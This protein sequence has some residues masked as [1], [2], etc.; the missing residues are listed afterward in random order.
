MSGEEL[1]YK[2]N[3]VGPIIRAG[4]LAN[5]AI[6]AAEIDNEGKELIVE[7]NMAYVRLQIEGEFIL[8]R[9]TLEEMLGRS[10]EMRELEINL[11]SFAGRIDMGTEQVRFYLTKTL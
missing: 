9:A 10:F 2:N 4:E 11:S 1:G 3:K 5:A 8:K 7:D 6:E